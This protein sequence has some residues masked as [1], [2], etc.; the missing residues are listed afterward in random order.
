MWNE[1]VFC[2]WLHIGF[3]KRCVR[4]SSGSENRGVLSC[5]GPAG[6][7]VLDSDTM[8]IVC[9]EEFGLLISIEVFRIMNLFYSM[10]QFY[11]LKVWATKTVR[12]IIYVENL[13]YMCIRL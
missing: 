4:M 6:F 8:F 12:S 2:R 11:I 9:W 1:N 13:N 10:L 5:S 3:V 7:F